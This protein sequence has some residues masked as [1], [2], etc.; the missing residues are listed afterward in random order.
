MDIKI[1]NK[2][3]REYLETKASAK[4]IA[5]CLSLCG[6]SV[7]RIENL[8]GDVVYSIEV[9]TNRPDAA[10]VLGIAREA[11]AILPRF[12]IPAKFVEPKLKARQKTSRTVSYLKVIV[13]PQLCSRFSVILIKN[14]KITPSPLEV[15]KKLIQS[16]ARPINNIVDISNYI[17]FLFGQP[18]HTFDYDKIKKA[19]M[20]L[21]TSLKGEKLT[22]LDGKTYKLS[23]DDIVIED[24]DKRL[25]DLAGIMGGLN[26]AVDENTKNVLL[27]VQTY[28]PLNIRKTSMSLA[29]R[30]QASM[31]FEK[32]LDAEMVGPAIRY[33]IDMFIDLT[34]GKPAAEILDIYPSPYKVKR[35]G[36]TLDFINQRLGVVLTKEQIS[37]TLLPLGF[38]PKW[39]GKNID[40]EIPTYR[41]DVSIPEDIVEEIARIYGYHNLPDKLLEGPLPEPLLD[42]PFE[43]EDKVKDFL[44]GWGATEI[45]T[46]SLVSKEEAQE[47]A[48]K[49]KNPLGKEAEYLRTSLMPSLSHAAKDNLGADEPFHFFEISNI[50]LP[51]KGG[52][53]EEEMTLAGVFSNYS[54][55]KAKGV[56]EALLDK[57]NVDYKFVPEDAKGFLPSQRLSIKAGGIEIGHLGVEESGK[58]I[59][60]EFSTELLRKNAKDFRPFKPIPKFPAQIEDITFS[61]PEKTYLG[62]V[63][64]K[65]KATDNLVFDV[66]LTDKYN[67]NYTFRIWYQHPE[68]T[69]TDADIEKIR[70]KIIKISRESFGASVK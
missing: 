56:I 30:T 49:L 10:S 31:L 25:I 23:G 47:N 46:L 12:K 6:P 70:G 68:K 15:Q 50:Y 13:D 66:K 60:Y 45:Y 44:C 18:V 22:T 19:K 2:W 32:G 58:L 36:T 27:F 34:Q 61:F 59:Y 65:M 35:V 3:L 29:V 48:L 42:T 51:R 52:L 5:E 7:N 17:M 40:A 63:I 21:R 54:Y 67:G 26:S 53:P 38:Y 41:K 11:S 33:A 37:K 8:E 1:P 55:K 43:F 14:V 62:D 24:G 69:L 4:K 28:N 20:I 16:G 39:T 9:T 64:K 57:L